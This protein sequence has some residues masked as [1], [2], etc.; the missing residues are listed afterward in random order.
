MSLTIASADWWQSS[1]PAA[2]SGPQKQNQNK[3]GRVGMNMLIHVPV[4]ADWQ[5]SSGQTTTETSEGRGGDKHADP[6]SSP[7]KNPN[8]TTTFC[9]LAGTQS[10]QFVKNRTI[11]GD[12]SEKRSGDDKHANPGPPFVTSFCWLKHQKQELVQDLTDNWKNGRWQRWVCWSK[13]QSSPH[14]ITSF[15]WLDAGL[16]ADSLLRTSQTSF[17]ITC[18]FLTCSSNSVPMRSSNIRMTSKAFFSIISA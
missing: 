3:I 16:C 2:C 17:R 11:N 1:M 4:P 15:C 5:H 6:P 13:P 14:L 12:N 8:K 18:H 9:W 10:P 7:Q